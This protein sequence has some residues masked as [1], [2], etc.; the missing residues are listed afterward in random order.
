MSLEDCQHQWAQFDTGHYSS[1]DKQV[2][3]RCTK[4]DR[5]R[6]YLYLDDPE[7]L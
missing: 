6:S 2:E 3:E 4:C 7:G 1:Y 5:K